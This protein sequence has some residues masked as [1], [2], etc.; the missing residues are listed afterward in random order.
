[1]K[2]KEGF[3]LNNNVFIITL[4]ITCLLMIFVYF[5]AIDSS[6]R[7]N[8]AIEIW[9]EATEV[10]G[11]DNPIYGNYQKNVDYETICKMYCVLPKD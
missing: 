10:I 6:K 5:R 9:Y 4:A 1:M 7:C 8:Q 3:Q 11:Q 2:K